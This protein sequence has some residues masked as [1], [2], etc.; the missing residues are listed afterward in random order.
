MVGDTVSDLK[1]AKA[2]GAVAVAITGGAGGR[3]ELEQ[4]A[5]I[6]ID[7]LEEICVI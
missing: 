4:Q 3:P 6:M 7:S 5:D 2:A 1:M